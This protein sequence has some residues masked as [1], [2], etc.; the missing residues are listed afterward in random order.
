MPMEALWK[1]KFPLF[2]SS[3]C[4]I[5]LDSVSSLEVLLDLAITVLRACIIVGL[6]GEFASDDG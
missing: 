1:N 2:P 6:G 5:S 3:F 4:W